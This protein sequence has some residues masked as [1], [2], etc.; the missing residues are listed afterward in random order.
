MLS[1]YLFLQEEAKKRDH[2]LIG[3]QLD[4]FSFKEVAAGMVFLHPKGMFIWN[5]LLEFLQ[6]LLEKKRLP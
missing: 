5:R 6:N 1:D 2:K 4:L 3:K